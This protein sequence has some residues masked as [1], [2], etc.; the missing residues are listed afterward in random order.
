[1]NAVT[2]LCLFPFY[3]R[4][5]AL[6]HAQ[7]PLSRVYLIH[8]LGM[9]VLGALLVGL[10]FFF[11]L[12]AGGH[13][14]PATPAIWKDAQSAAVAIVVTICGEAVFVVV[15]SFMT[16][17]AG[18]DEP[19]AE[20]W[21]FALRVSWLYVAHLIWVV[22]ICGTT[23][24]TA[25]TQNF[26]GFDPSWLLLT[27]TVIAGMII[28]SIVSYLR[29]LTVPRD[30]PVP[31]ADPLCEWCGY[32]LAHLDPAGRCPEC[33]RPIADST[34][35]SPRKSVDQ[36]YKNI[37]WQ[38]ADL[39]ANSWFDAER[40]FREITTRD[41]ARRG[42]R[43]V[44]VSIIL[45]AVVGG[46]TFAVAIT[47]ATGESAPAWAYF[48]ITIVCGPFVAFWLLMIISGSATIQ[49]YHA[50]RRAGR[51]RFNAAFNVE[52]FTSGALTLWVACATI[53]MGIY[54]VVGDRLDR[55]EDQLLKASW[56]AANAIVVVLYSGAITRR[57]KYVQFANR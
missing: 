43:M 28:W 48:M 44:V 33:G 11:A 7:T 30:S 15:A 10:D 45:T 17:W 40:V 39:I 55:L 53:S 12:V 23:M 32:N 31:A 9:M 29:A 35:N 26:R 25:N 51:N 13:G 49:G 56:F 19:I 41:R 6:A 14:V 50:S 18:R 2:T 16:C 4:R 20:T 52:A 54:M 5:V 37:N 57:V 46:S 24:M 47:I 1:M 34:D 38:D 42:V 3:P 21:H 22:G 8:W 36:D 27:V